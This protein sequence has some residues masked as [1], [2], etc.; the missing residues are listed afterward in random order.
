MASFVAEGLVDW[1]T[2]IS[3]N[4]SAIYSIPLVLAGLARSR[5]LLWLF[6]IALLGLTF[7]MYAIENGSSH[8]AGEMLLQNRLLSVV[9]M[10]VTALLMHALIGVLDALEKRDM[11]IRR[12]NEE[13]EQRREQAERAS[14]RKT[15]LLASV[16]HD[17]RTP[18]SVI[19]LTARAIGLEADRLAINGNIPILAQQQTANA[20]SVANLVSDVLDYSALE[21]GRVEVHAAECELRALIKEVSQRLLPLAEVKGLQLRVE[22]PFDARTLRTDPV[23]LERVLTNLI[24]NAIKYTDRG[25]V[26]VSAGYGDTSEVLVYVEDTGIG[27]PEDQRERIFDEFA[28]LQPSTD[29]SH[30]WG[31]GLPICR[32]LITL[33][34]GTISVESRPGGGSVFVVR[35]PLSCD[36]DIPGQLQTSRPLPNGAH[37][38]NFELPPGMGSSASS[39]LPN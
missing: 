20:I 24:M 27:V 15:L 21:L 17:V 10:L 36:G 3:L 13:L 8:A 34:K 2:P 19:N 9:T 25:S 23:K 30:G 16:S 22:A 7:L 38:G 31:L 39:S 29:G 33:L 11:Q 14:T 1:A 4:I 28:R 35:L 32:R 18:L 5:R 6:L 26:R 12:Q 37:D